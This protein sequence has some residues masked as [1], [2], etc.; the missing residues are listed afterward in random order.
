M[1]MTGANFLARSTESE[2][3][4]FS[5]EATRLSEQAAY[6][7]ANPPRTGRKSSGDI[8][9]LIQT[10]TF[11]LQRAAAIEATLEAVGVMGAEANTTEQ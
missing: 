3:A 10:A 6:I 9:R 1:P 8:A 4:R 5:E 7:A 2:Q 11:L